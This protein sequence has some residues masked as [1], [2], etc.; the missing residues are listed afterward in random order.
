TFVASDDSGAYAAAIR[1]E[2]K[3]VYTELIANPS[4]SIA[5]LGGLADV[6]HRRGIPLVVDATLATPALCRPLDHG[7]DIVVHSATNFLGGHGTSIRG[8]V[9]ES[10]RCPWDNRT[11]RSMVEPVPSH[12]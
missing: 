7:A 1:P 5:D 3:L 4:G 2:T 8:G 10:G 9:V 6:A 12:G 11:F